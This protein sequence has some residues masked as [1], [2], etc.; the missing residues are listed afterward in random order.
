MAYFESHGF[1]Y[2][3]YRMDPDGGVSQE[4]YN[5]PAP[6][7]TFARETVERFIEGEPWQGRTQ[8]MAVIEV[9]LGG[10]G[11]LRLTA[12]DREQFTEDETETLREFAGAVA[13][14]YARYLDIRTIQENTEK[15]S[16]F[17]A[18]MSHELRTPM[19]AIKG[20]T[21][22]VLRRAGEALP[23]RQREN[24]VK[25]T[26]ASDHL[27]AMINDI[28]DLSKI[29][30]GRMDV[31]PE[32]FDVRSLVTSC[33]DTV[34]PLVGDTVL[35]H[36]DVADDIGEAKTDQARVRQ[37]LINLLSNALKFTDEGHVTV[38][39]RSADGTLTLSVT[40]TGKGIPD[41]ELP[42]IFDEYRQV[43]GSESSV[44]KGTGLGLSITKKFAELLGGSIGVESEIG[45]GSTFT[46]RVPVKYE[47]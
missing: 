47:A 5:T 8:Q 24:L 36:Q 19:N 32:S 26:H 9:P 28:L 27:L 25:V 41:D 43:K 30:A 4:S 29:E 34:T 44:Q 20:F 37:M 16:A 13:L 35:L 23:D 12:P 21:N 22:L 31:N 11:R 45:K 46:V 3:T 39:A 15:K 18:S 2:T 1:R 7:P 38:K 33:C 42:T 17:L 14:G 10:Y 6:F 40:D